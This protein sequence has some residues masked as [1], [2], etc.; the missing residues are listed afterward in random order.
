MAQ[1]KYFYFLYMF[2]NMKMS[3][4]TSSGK[5]WKAR[6]LKMAGYIRMKERGRKLR[7]RSVVETKKE[8]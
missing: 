2:Y 5:E 6:K 7:E 4:N 1:N 8:Y 3:I